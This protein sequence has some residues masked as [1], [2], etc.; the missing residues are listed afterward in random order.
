MPVHALSVV[1]CWSRPLPALHLCPECKMKPTGNHPG[2]VERALGASSA[3]IGRREFIKAGIAVAAGEAM[4]AQVMAPT[5]K[6]ALEEHFTT[7]DLA[8]RNVARPTRSDAIFAD[9][10]RRL[11]DF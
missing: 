5:R 11:V 10:E 4:G 9:I 1:R 3:G 8:K 6:I 2:G 7:P